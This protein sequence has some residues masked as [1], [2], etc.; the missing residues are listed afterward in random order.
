MGGMIWYDEWHRESDR[1][2]DGEEKRDSEGQRY[3][4]TGAGTMREDGISNEV[5]DC[6]VGCPVTCNNN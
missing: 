4:E 3:Q 5:V 6:G 1:Y 2:Q